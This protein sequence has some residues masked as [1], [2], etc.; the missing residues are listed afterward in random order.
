VGLSAFIAILSG[1]D[2]LAATPVPQSRKHG[3]DRHSRFLAEDRL[4]LAI[5]PVMVPVDRHQFPDPPH[6]DFAPVGMTVKARFR[7]MVSC[8][9]VYPGSCR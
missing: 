5:S 2:F 4:Y 1:I 8:L 9:L 7:Y 3:L 6:F